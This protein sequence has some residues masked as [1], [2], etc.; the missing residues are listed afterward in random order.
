[1]QS[2]AKKTIAAALALTLAF[3]AAGAAP[4]AN[5][6][7]KIKLSKSKLSIEVK[8]TKK[9]TIKNIK[10]KK[11]KKITV[12][13]N[14]KSIATAK[15][16][17]K[18]AI[19]VTGKKAGKAKITVK[20]TQKGKKK[21]TKLTLNVTVKKKKKTD[22]TP[23]PTAGS[24]TAVTNTTVPTTGSKTPAPSQAPA[25]KT[26]P[27]VRPIST[28]SSSEGTPRPS[29]TPLVKYE[30][31]FDNGLG[32]W[33][34]RY[35]EDQG[36]K[37]SLINTDEAHS[38]K[39]MRI[40]GRVGDDGVSHPWN[41]PALD[42]SASGTPG[43]SYKVS[44]WARLPEEYS[45]IIAGDEVKMRVSGATK[46]TDDAEEAYVNYP[47]DTDYLISADEWRHFEVD[48][49]LSATFTSYIFYFETN[50]GGKFDFIIDDLT[51][52]RT[53]APAEPDL[54]LPSIK[55]TYAP[56]IGT[57][58]TALTYSDLLNESTLSFVKHHYG[59]V[60]MGNS[61]KPD[62][63]MN[64]KKVLLQS[65][66]DYILPEDYS[67]YDANKDKDGNVIVPEFTLAEVDK[68]LKV[69]QENGLKLRV[70]S[71]MWH[72]QMP[73]FFFCEQ[74]DENK[75][76]VTD[77]NVILAREEMYI[78]NI[79]QYFLTSPWADAI[80]AFDVVNE[81]THMDNISEA[82]GSDN[83]WKYSFGTEMK[84]DCEYVKKAF[85]WAN[86]VLELCERTDIS[87]I[88]NDYN[89]YEPKTTESI[90][91]LVNNI[92]KKDDVNKVGKICDGVGMQSHMNDKN[93]TV[94]NYAAALEK[95]SAQGYEIQ[96]TELDVTNCG[97]IT[98]ETTPEE[99]DEIYAANA[100]MYAGVMD[101]ILNA[102]KNGANITNV[103]IW[104]L[105]DATSWRADRAPLLFGTDISDKKPSFDAVINA[106]KN[107]AG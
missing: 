65:E 74:Y 78:R 100:E 83:W 96:I 6:A 36:N 86:E 50:G 31:S 33:Y 28:S 35:A 89:T 73:K 56:Y 105:T 22:S 88:Y 90:I 94:E 107:F 23:A 80:I 5:A 46:I 45:E 79:Y 69:C 44:F 87:L 1:M 95:F 12:S 51:M 61:M 24:T 91:E 99:K 62:A 38:G 102:K 9:V 16:S 3:T 97:Q 2:K 98:S 17:G 37:A 32:D 92:N 47:A 34:A 30:E 27:T 64:S 21:P 41:G 75:P 71:P 63:L 40:T 103:T 11:V 57:M 72:Q 60:T 77:K 25:G 85:V 82:V 84:T 106:A 42:M 104:G 68:V 101:A 70:H 15:K 81:Y 19:K 66:A 93:A 13:T 14:K 48:F 52:E 55:D 49:T 54:T 43:A 29:A 10:A 53:A 59:S 20:L 4:Q 58:G 76:V 8:K 7:K 67:T 39:A 26:K 18:T